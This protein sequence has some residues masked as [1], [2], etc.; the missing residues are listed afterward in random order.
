M[1]IV[2]LG[3]GGLGR[4]CEE[5]IAD[6]N[7]E[8]HRFNLV[9]FLDSDRA[10][11]GTSIHD[12]EVHGDIDWLEGR[13][14]IG[15]VLGIGSTVAKLRVVERLR[16]YRVEFP[17]LIHPNA[18]IGEHVTYGRGLVASP[19]SIVTTDVRLGDF[20]TL[21]FQL[22]IG[23]DG[24]VGD[25]VTLAP[26]VHLS[27]YVEVGDGCDLGAGAVVLPSKKVGHWSIV[28]AGAVVNRD[29]PDDCTAVGVPARV[30]KT[31]SPG[32]QLSK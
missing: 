6:A 21:N 5:W 27:G 12:H 15:V 25:Y 22:T 26:G 4:E 14:G 28:G 13:S 3:C 11:H 9:G 7:A 32:W 31:R 29:L 20:V 23:H 16:P 24:R 30:I 1:D 19:G 18:V 17:A 10:K 8:R 2:I